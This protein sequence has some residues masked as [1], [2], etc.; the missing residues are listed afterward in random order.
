MKPSPPFIA[1]ERGLKGGILVLVYTKKDLTE[2]QG[3]F[4]Y[5]VGNTDVVTACFLLQYSRWHEALVLNAQD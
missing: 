5:I 1:N 4:V 3:L 2:L